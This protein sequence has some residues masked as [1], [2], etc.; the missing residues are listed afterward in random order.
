MDDGIGPQKLARKTAGGGCNLSPARDLSGE[1]KKIGGA[2]A[3]W[4]DVPAV[5]CKPAQRRRVGSAFPESG[6]PSPVVDAL[7]EPLKD[8]EVSQP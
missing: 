4:E 8:L 6:R 5:G 7:T 3:G 1:A 2:Y